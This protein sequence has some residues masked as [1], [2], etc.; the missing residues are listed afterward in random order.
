M[1]AA[2]F[3]FD[4]A[5]GVAVVG[6]ERGEGGDGVFAVARGEYLHLGIDGRGGA[7]AE[8]LVDAGG[9]G[10]VTGEHSEV[11][12]ANLAVFDRHLIFAGGL[13]GFG[14]DDDSAGFAV[15]PGDDV[16]AVGLGV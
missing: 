7:F 11:G 14:E 2:R 8:R 1:A 16:Q 5:G 9:R 13:R 10:E 4:L 6:F 15:E 12:F 3:D